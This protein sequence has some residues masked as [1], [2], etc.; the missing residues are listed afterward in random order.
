MSS[1]GGPR[2]LCTMVDSGYL[3]FL[4][5]LHASVREHAPDWELHALCLDER[6]HADLE[7]LGLDGLR[8]LPFAELLEIEPGLGTVREARP[9]TEFA[10]ACKPLAIRRL[11]GDPLEP[12]VVTWLDADAMCFASLEPV[13][14]ELG[15]A[16]VLLTPQRVAPAF[17]HVEERTGTFIAGLVGFRNDETGREVARWW[18]DRCLLGG[19]PR[20]PDGLRFGDQ[21]YLDGIPGTFSGVRVVADPGLH[22]GPFSLEA[23]EV[24]AGEAGPLVDGR[25][26]VTYHYTGFREFPDGDFEASYPPWRIGREERRL[27]Y[28]PL[29]ERL[30]AARAALADVDPEFDGGFVP[31]RSPLE[32]A[33]GAGS[34]AKGWLLRGRHA[35]RRPGH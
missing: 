17:A 10:W 33:T 19:C 30:R 6:S 21:K 11:L 9:Y 14:G 15:D 24:S 5:A 20:R 13:L 1:A 12:T 4:L 18:A 32:R 27:L 35:V 25:P 16:S 7:R 28:E 34:R 8:P 22:L 29:R 31:R 2:H 3:P 23:V 26:V